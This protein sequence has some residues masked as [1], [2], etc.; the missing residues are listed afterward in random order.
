MPITFKFS[1]SGVDT[2][3]GEGAGHYPTIFCDICNSEI[4]HSGLGRYVYDD[5][6]TKEHKTVY[7]ICSPRCHD[8]IEYQIEKTNK[9]VCHWDHLFRFLGHLTHN[10]KRDESEVDIDVEQLDKGRK[11][12]IH[13]NLLMR[14]FDVLV[15][16]RENNG[17][18]IDKKL[19]DK[20]AEV[21]KRETQKGI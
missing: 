3:L 16:L 1:K 2:L 20:I 13:E 15:K 7:F 14:C 6:D 10:V 19:T 21:L 17:V 12:S 18:L 4:K 9:G 5:K 8:I 11:I